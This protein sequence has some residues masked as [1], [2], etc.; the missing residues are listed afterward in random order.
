MGTGSR[1]LEAYM[2]PSRFPFFLSAFLALS[3][4][5]EMMQVTPQLQM[6]SADKKMEV[7]SKVM[8]VSVLAYSPDGKQLASGGVTPVVRVW[9]MANAK[10]VRTLDLPAQYGLLDVGYSPDGKLLAA[11]GR[12]GI[13]GGDLTHLWDAET[14]KEIRAIPGNFGN[15]LAFSQDGAYLLGS[16]F[17]V[18][19]LLGVPTF[20]S[21]QF[22][23]RSGEMLRTFPGHTIGAMSPDGQHVLLIGDRQKGLALVELQSGREVWRAHDRWAS[24]AAF[25]SDRR[26]L[27]SAHFEFHGALGTSATIFVVLRDATTGN[28]IRELVRYDVGNTFFAHEKEYQKL[29]VLEASPDGSRFVTG[30]DRGEYKLWDTASGQLIRQMKR[31]DEKIILD[32]SPAHAA[33]SP[34]GKLLALTSAASVRVFNVASGEEVA[35]LIAFDDGEWLV[36]TPSGYYNSSEKGDQ[37]LSVSV[38]GAPFTIAQ[39]R[40]SFY[41]PDLVKVALA[42][43]TLSDYKKVAD[44]KPPPAVTI[45]DTPNA[46][47]NPKITV[48]LKVKDQG[49]GIGDVR[50]YRNGAAVV[51]E[52]S[53]NLTVGS[54]GSQV[55]RYELHLEPGS[56]TIRAIAFNADNSMQSIDTTID[57]QANIAKRPPALHALVIGIKDFANP[58]LT[59]KY[60]VADANLFAA[61]LEA[62]GQ[63]LFSSIHVKRL[64]KPAETTNVAIVEALQQARLDVGPED[65]FVFYVAS[66]GT[67]DDGQ[68][69]LITSNVGSTTTARLKQD[70]LTQD[71]LKEMISNI[72]ASKKLVVLDTCSA[73]QL[74]DAIQVAMLTRGMSDDTAMKVLSR[75][76]GSTVL[77][78]A[79]SVQEALEGYKGHGLFTYVIV[80]G[81]NG[82]ADTD[83]D[84]FVKTLELADY[85]DNKVPELAEKVF[86]HKQY[87][88]VSPT[89]QGFPLVRTR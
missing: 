51:F 28:S 88:I 26:Y 11:S 19:G 58:R 53:R 86:Q 69:L 47:A 9:D 5:A 39:L 52:K 1:Y 85:V 66:H 73:G 32:L 23:L 16:E 78:A 7:R 84:G 71:R 4:C 21:K 82:A 43:G 72:P 12:T 61:T 38:A 54:E 8:A 56:N 59:L 67:V 68:Y 3:G 2:N 89:G 49:G 62:K 15:R 48:F 81:L 70:A 55:L 14:G 63:G 76:V 50:L 34:N 29:T 30:N 65:L 80:E 10:G 64:T 46:T 44:I 42:G 45:V 75:A 33:F 36:T 18:G 87:P 6:E 17:D 13:F 25:T 31:P 74:G 57:V 60:S 41:R 77:S 83:R 37:Y 20:N 24:A 27:L 79:T 40:E 35:T 22:S